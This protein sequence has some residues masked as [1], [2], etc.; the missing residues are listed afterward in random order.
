MV[1]AR[2]PFPLVEE[3]AEAARDILKAGDSH[4]PAQA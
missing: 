4:D 2:I 1:T 3:K